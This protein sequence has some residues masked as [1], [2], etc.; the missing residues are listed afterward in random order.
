MVSRGDIQ[1]E[2]AAVNNE[3]LLAR[4]D[5]AINITLPAVGDDGKVGEDVNGNSKSSLGV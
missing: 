5:F 1:N 2:P 4:V 3:Q